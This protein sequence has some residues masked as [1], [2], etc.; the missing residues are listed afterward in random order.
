MSY[1][2]EELYDNIHDADWRINNLYSI[3]DKYAKVIPYNMNPTQIVLHNSK[4][5]FNMTLKGRQQGVST[6]YLI[7]YLDKC[8]WND[9]QTIGIISHDKKSI[10]KLFRIPAFVYSKCPDYLKPRLGQGGGSK[11]MLYF[12]ERNSR[13][14]V[15]LEIRS[16][17]L[18]HL[19]ISEYGLMK[20]KDRFNASVEAVPLDF[21]EI[22]I[23]STCF[24]MNHFYD[25]WV[26]PN[27][28]YNKHFFPW[29]F[30]YENQIPV[31]FNLI[32]TD[33]EKYFIELVKKNFNIKI[34]Q[35][36][37]NW[38]RFKIMQ[39]QSKNH[40]MQEHPEDDIN[41]FLVSG[42]PVMDLYEIQQMIKVLKDPLFEKGGI[43]IYKE[44]N[45]NSTYVLGADTAEGVGSDY[46]TGTIIEKETMTQ[47]AQFRGHIKPFLFAHKLNEMAEM[48][49]TDAGLPLLGVERNN[50]GHAVL[51]EL[52]ENIEYANLY[53][54]KDEKVGWHTN[55]VTRPIMIDT[56]L[57]AVENRTYT[58]KDKDTLNECLTLIDNNGKIEAMSGKHDDTIISSSIALQMAIAKIETLIPRVSLL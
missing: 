10:E 14:Y 18:T 30:H 41:C 54:A 47:V 40:F 13:I 48:Y 5:R 33:E 15:D 16:E 36:Q 28:P 31:E 58:L 32:Y 17:S 25:D 21:G 53:T 52:E 56:F 19:H 35:Q 26:D 9:N 24:G 38:R 7:K 3:K 27:F 45:R 11:Y 34:T 43:K 42:N 2:K 1:T 51:L 57:E 22:S 37:I 23:E 46:S 20:N 8:M 49:K 50:H 39:A 4:S 44:R 6:Y 12:P 55:K 29:F